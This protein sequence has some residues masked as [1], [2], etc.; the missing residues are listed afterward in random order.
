MKKT[1][2]I[3]LGV[4]LLAALGW[5]VF[6]RGSN[7]DQAT[8]GSKPDA[9]SAFADEAIITYTDNGFAP[10]TLTVAAGEMVT[11]VNESSEQLEFSS[12]QHPLH[13]DNPELNRDVLLP[14]ESDSFVVTEPGTWSYHNHLNSG[15]TGTIVV[16]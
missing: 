10:L 8:N 4:V 14:G 16:E 1:M 6:L 9:E 15:K 7:G 3:L 2:I 12:N 5:F 13:N 11:V